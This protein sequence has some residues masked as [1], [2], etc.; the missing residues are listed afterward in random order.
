M[1]T[2]PIL[3]IVAMGETFY[4][5]VSDGNYG[6][7]AQGW[8]MALPW[9]NKL[10]LMAFRPDNRICLDEA[11]VESVA[12]LGWT[13]PLQEYAAKYGPPPGIDIIVESKP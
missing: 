6:G 10:K 4:M 13:R 11:H 9:G 2:W 5:D 7:A 1:T 3:V 12:L 8:I